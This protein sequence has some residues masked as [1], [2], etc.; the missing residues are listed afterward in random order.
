MS[1]LGHRDVSEFKPDPERVRKAGGRWSPRSRRKALTGDSRSGRRAGAA[2][3]PGKKSRGGPSPGTIALDPRGGLRLDPMAAIEAPHDKIDVGGGGVA[4]CHRRAAVGVYSHR[5]FVEHFGQH[6]PRI[7]QK[8][9]SIARCWSTKSAN[10]STV[11]AFILPPR[12]LRYLIN[13]KVEPTGNASFG[14][15]SV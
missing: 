5:P 15:N 9:T 4:E 13:Q 3:A 12:G 7:E 1:F 8:M 2:Q 11:V 14:S 6:C 10:L